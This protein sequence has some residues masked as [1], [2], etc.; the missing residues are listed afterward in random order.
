MH[1][2]MCFD[3]Y[4][5][6]VAMV[7]SL[8]AGCHAQC[9]VWC[10]LTPWRPHTGTNSSPTHRNTAVGAVGCGVVSADLRSA[11]RQYVPLVPRT[12]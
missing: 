3:L 1:A 8:G 12:D 5:G 6:G 10:L 4:V 9:P 11:V 2:E 7:T